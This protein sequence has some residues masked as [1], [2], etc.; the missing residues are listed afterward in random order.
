MSL[1]DKLEET[2]KNDEEWGRDNPKN[3][4]NKPNGK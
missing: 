2:A 4:S 1:M 3:P